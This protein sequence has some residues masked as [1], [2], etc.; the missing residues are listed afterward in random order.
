MFNTSETAFAVDLD[1]QIVAWNQAAEHTF[2]HA[3]TDALGQRCWELLSGRDVFGNRFCC[4]GCPVRAAAFDNEPISR[5]QIDFETATD[6]R[7]R[8]TVSTLILSNGPGKKVLVH[9]CN[10]SEEATENTVIGRT[11]IPP[12]P[13]KLYRPLTARETEVLALLYR[14]SVVSEIAAVMGISV[15]TVRNHTQH[16]LSKLHVH[17]RLEAVVLG[18]KLGLI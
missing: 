15:S 5:F 17:T 6:E 3:E 16:V 10:L 2:G 7:N 9:L 12:T 11:K 13:V 4:E 1:G 8:F 18:C 14:G